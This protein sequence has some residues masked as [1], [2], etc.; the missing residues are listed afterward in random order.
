MRKLFYV[1]LIFATLSMSGCALNKMIKAAKDQD[2][3]V[4]PNPLE[5]HADT[6]AFEISAVLPTKMLQKGKIYTVN[7]FYKY[8]DAEIAFEGIEFQADQFASSSTEQPRLSKKFSFAY[9][10]A[11]KSGEVQMMGVAL[12][13]K[14]GKTKESER[15][16][17]AD[18][19]ITT[20]KLIQKTYFAAYAPHGYNNAEEME[21]INVNFYFDQGKSNLKRS[22]INSDRGKYFQGFI[23]EKNV[24]RTV[25][26]TGTH[27]PEGAERI[28][29]RLSPDRAKTIE[30]YYKAQ[31]KRYDYKG[32]ADSINFILKPIIRDWAD[33]MTAL[34]SYEGITSEEKSAYQNIINGSGTFEEKENGMHKLPTY[35]KVF[36]DVYPGLRTAKTDILTVKD[37]K[38]DAE[39]SV[40]SK[41][42]AQNETSADTLSVEELMY[43]AT[44]TPSLT[45]KEAIYKAAIAKS[46]D[47]NSHN[48]L[49]AVYVQMAIENPSEATSY[50]DM[51]VTQLQISI[52]KQESAEAYIN[53]G[54]AQLMQGNIRAAL[55]SLRTSGTKNPS[56]DNAR[57]ANGVLGALEAMTAQYDRAVI[58]LSN[59]QETA[60]NLF[61]KGLAQLLN[62]DFNNA[63]A[64]FQEAIQKDGNLALASYGAAVANA[65]LQNEAR[66]IENL[67]NAVT[68]DPSLKELA[69]ND[70]EFRN[71]NI[72]SALN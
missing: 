49:G 41:Q 1:V 14:N 10:D 20:S 12:D 55:A 35:R 42:V 63:L 23:A 33:F 30:D 15:L 56:G 59:S 68:K 40:L 46:D 36:R 19:V 64:S 3:T 58:A 70:L 39:I 26:I 66:V 6:V 61:N 65:R 62:K 54:S 53:L 21:P 31:M 8:G 17:V 38:S 7:S 67:T 9:T 13:P 37:K 4:V 69:L 28:N 29:S 16:K 45:E 48:N 18:G 71:F 52:N 34:A 44:L 24:T 22:E 50:A 47:W 43:G 32:M 57:G 51:A 25:T 60:V 27:S 11:M 72:S 2:L 5:V